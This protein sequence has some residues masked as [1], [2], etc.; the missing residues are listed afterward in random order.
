[1]TLWI[2]EQV[3]TSED[4]EFGA[5]LVAVQEMLNET[6]RLIVQVEVDGTVYTGDQLESLANLALA[7]HDVKLSTESPNTLAA[8]TL[9][10]VQA[11]LADLRQ[12]Q[13][14]AAELMQQDKA[15]EGLDSMQQAIT[16]WLQINQAVGQS[17]ALCEVDLNSLQVDDQP[18]TN[19]L[20]ETRHKLEELKD[21]LVEKDT[22]ALSDVLGYEWPELVQQ[23]DE[24]LTVLIQAIKAK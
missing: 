6:G 2:D 18:M 8:E 13:E 15:G 1:M 22:V 19:I 16:L 23:W 12:L 20:D 10:A 4:A 17:A 21:M 24:L 11:G 14:S 5:M 7:E 9:Q 3:H